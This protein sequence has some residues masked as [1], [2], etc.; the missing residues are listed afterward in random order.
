V[1]AWSWPPDA[2]EEQK[3]LRRFKNAL[4]DHLLAALLVGR[5]RRG[6][7]RLIGSAAAVEKAY[8]RVREHGPK[9][10]YGER[11]DYENL[12]STLRSTKRS[13]EDL[14]PRQ[15]LVRVLASLEYRFFWAACSR[16][17]AW[18]TPVDP[19]GI[20]RK[21]QAGLEAELLAALYH[22]LGPAFD[23]SLTWPAGGCEPGEA[24]DLVQTE[25][26]LASLAAVGYCC[27]RDTLV[28]YE[29]HADEEAYIEGFVEGS[30]ERI[31]EQAPEEANFLRDS[32]EG[33][34]DGSEVLLDLLKEEC[35]IRAGRFGDPPCRSR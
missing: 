31:G 32:W 30:L 29:G 24:G 22:E 5:D 4:M 25:G 3:C 11:T 20:E 26:R 15:T 17:S 16:G 7:R 34:D 9:G 19:A 2:T 14:P 13:H 18:A 6:R 33:G 10:S 12:F 21:P 35:E 27:G 8:A 28:F 1:T 23:V